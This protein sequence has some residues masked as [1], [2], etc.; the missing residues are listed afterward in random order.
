LQADA[1]VSVQ[2]QS[3]TP[4]M[5]LAMNLHR[6]V[7]QHD[8]ALPHTARATVDFRANQ[9]ATVLPLQFKSP[10]LNPTEHLWDDSDHVCTVVD[11]RHKICKNYSRL[12]S[13]IGGE[14]RKTVFVD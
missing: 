4:H 9:N 1:D 13:K 3:M 2:R 10:D 11:Q 5:L 12:L 14:F 8:N 7:H 6:E